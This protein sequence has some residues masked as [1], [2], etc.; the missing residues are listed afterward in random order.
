MQLNYQSYVSTGFSTTVAYYT[1]AHSFPTTNVAMVMVTH[2]HCC[3]VTH[4][5]THSSYLL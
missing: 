5:H 3:L 1:A 4:Q 2:Q